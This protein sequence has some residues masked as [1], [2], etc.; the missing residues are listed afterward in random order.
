MPRTT[1]DSS[2]AFHS[3]RSNGVRFFSARREWAAR[4]G[5]ERAAIL[6]KWADLCMVHQDDLGKI[7]TAEIGLRAFLDGGGDFLHFFVTGRA[8]Q[9]LTAGDEAIDDGQ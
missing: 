3:K 1:A 7:L 6:R 8:S 4:T 5:K 2:D 9:H